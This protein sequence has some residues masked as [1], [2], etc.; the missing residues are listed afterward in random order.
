MSKIWTSDKQLI[1]GG[2]EWAEV[3]RPLRMLLSN[4]NILGHLKPLSALPP[5]SNMLLDISGS[6]A[7]MLHA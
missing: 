4:R 5:E 2:L 1:V 3:I 6:S 7:T